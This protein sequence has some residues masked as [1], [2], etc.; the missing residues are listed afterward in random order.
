MILRS[1]SA[2]MAAHSRATAALRDSR[3]ARRQ[4]VACSGRDAVSYVVIAF[5]NRATV[6]S[7]S[8]THRQ[9]ND[10]WAINASNNVVPEPSTV[11]LLGTGLAGLAAAVRRRRRA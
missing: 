10:D 9:S 2:H 6:S 5:V 4:D 11:V 1:A 3:S 7:M 8:C